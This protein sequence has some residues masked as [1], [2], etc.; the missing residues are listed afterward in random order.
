MKAT[1]FKLASLL[2]LFTGAGQLLQA[3]NE[4]A[5]LAQ[6]A[7]ENQQAVDALVLYPAET[8]H[9][10]LE[11]ALF[12]EALIKLEGM[13]SQTSASFRELVK[14]YPKETQDLFWDLARYPGLIR[15]LAVEAGPSR[16][17]LET[18]VKDYPE[19]IRE[20]A[21]Q[22]GLDYP[23]LLRKIN[24]LQSAAE[25][26]FETTIR[27]YPPQTQ[28]ALRH[29]IALPEVLTL[30]TDNIRLTILTGSLYRKEPDWL[31]R[32]A[33]SL[34]RVVAQRNAAE[35]EDW[36]KS[37]EE[38]PTAKSEFAAAAKTYE[39]ENGD[40]GEADNGDDL[41]YDGNRA[42]SVTV[43]EH[44][45]Y[46]YPYWFG[47]PYWYDYPRWR[48]YP[49]WWDWGF[50][51]GPNRVIVVVGLPSYHFTH[52]Y[53]YHPWH[54]DR[55]HH[56][57]GHFTRHY[58]HHRE[59]GG[60]ISTGV[61]VWQRRH[62]TII[63]ENWLK[64]DGNLPTRFREFGKFEAGRTKFNRENPNNPLD[65]KTY[66]TRNAGRYPAMARVKP[67]DDILEQPVPR[68]RTKAPVPEP[69]V[70]GQVPQP[71]RE[72]RAKR[73]PVEPTVQPA[74]GR[75]KKPT[76]P[77][78]KPAPGREKQ[79]TE[80]VPERAPRR[81]TPPAV[82]QGREHHEN[83]LEKSKAQ[84]N[85]EPQRAPTPRVTPPQTKQAPAPA[86]ATRERKP[87]KSNNG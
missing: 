73:E 83:V 19:A 44:H 70:R 21:L 8:R 50:Y 85:A 22:A 86:P 64:D 75:E 77:T 48:P 74:P 24:D 62:G 84:R 55:W 35:V 46:H 15:R 78:V 26:A 68:P 13:Q 81:T 11:A 23:I 87:T 67:A 17:N 29:L 42:P 2:L 56:L 49:W 80:T 9:D 57:S 28:T 25:A 36:K 40:R 5:L 61:V 52:W 79:P 20:K 71:A 69:D 58:H 45:S 51:Y 32:Q 76:E 82:D 60:S 34:H 3:Q 30:L 63:T 53:F 27:E 47:Y 7:E 4:K 43:V 31:M 72:P 59:S 65:E 39:A 6:V 54:H 38:D 10:I 16:S 18:V 1:Y 12:P 14:G 37:L 66:L 33:D 41:Y